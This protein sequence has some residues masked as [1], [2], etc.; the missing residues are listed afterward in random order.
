VRL[1]NSVEFDE[2][3]DAS[4]QSGRQ[5]GEQ[6]KAVHPENAPQDIYSIKH[7]ILRHFWEEVFDYRQNTTPIE[8]CTSGSECGLQLRTLLFLF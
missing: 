6:N 5:E 7:G 8:P 3:S 1:I 4:G 2:N